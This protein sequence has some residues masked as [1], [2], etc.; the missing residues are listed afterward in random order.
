MSERGAA[1]LAQ[2][3]DT[4]QAAGTLISMSAVA[5]SG[6]A[7][8][9]IALV[10]GVLRR[11]EWARYGAILS[12]LF[13]GVTTAWMSIASGISPPRPPYWWVGMLFGFGELAVVV[14][15]LM[16]VT[17]EDFEYAEWMRKR[18]AQLAEAREREHQ[19]RELYPVR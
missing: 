4:P 16:S 19:R 3:A 14:L 12:F 15:L 1:A 17:A 5:L 11:K 10:V 13:F 6:V 7:I 18:L 8:Y 9:I 2:M